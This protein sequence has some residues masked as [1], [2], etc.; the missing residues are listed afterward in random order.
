[1]YLSQ[2]D[3][4]GFKSFAHKTSIKF[5]DGITAIVGPNGCGKTNIV[6]AIRWV[7]GEQKSSVLRS[8]RMD[9][10][11][12]GGTT[13]RR[14]LGFAEVSLVIENTKNILP[15]DYSQVM[16]SRRL[17]RSGDSEYLLNK[18]VCRLKDISNLLMDSGM[19]ADAY[20]VIEL[21]MIEMLLKD[22]DDFRK[23]LFEEAA[24]ITKYKSRRQETLRKLDATRQ[25]LIRVKDII[26]EVERNVN[27]LKSQVNRANRYEK[28]KNELMTVEKLF[29]F[30]KL[31]DLHKRKKPIEMEVAALKNSYANLS[32]KVAKDKAAFEKAQ[33]EIIEKQELLAQAQ[34]KLNKF[35]EHV[36]ATD[37]SIATLRERSAALGETQKRLEIEIASLKEDAEETTA[38]I[39]DSRKQHVSIEHEL[40]SARKKLNE[41]RDKRNIFLEEYKRKKSILLDKNQKAF[42]VLKNLEEKK[43]T[44]DTLMH[45]SKEREKRLES[46]HES[47]NKS[48]GKLK[49]LQKTEL[50]IS[51]QKG[52]L[53]NKIVEEKKNIEELRKSRD[54]LIEEIRNHEL[55]IN[56]L[57]VSLETN[58]TKYQFLDN[59]VEEYGGLPNGVSKILQAKDK[60]AGILG[61]IADLITVPDQYRNAVE[62]ILGEQAHYIVVDSVKNVEKALSYLRSLNSG[63]A[64]FVALDK[65]NADIDVPIHRNENRKD[66]S[67][68]LLVD[69]IKSDKSLIPL[70]NVL[71][72]DVVYVEGDM[73]D[74][75]IR[76]T[77]PCRLVN[78]SGEIVSTDYLYSGGRSKDSDTNI[79]G[80]KD[81]MAEIDGI[82]QDS[83][84]ELEKKVSALQLIKEENGKIISKLSE[85]EYM[86]EN[87]SKELESLH[88]R[89]DIVMYEKNKLEEELEKMISETKQLELFKTDTTQMS[90]IDAEISR[91]ESKR[92]SLEDERDKVQNEEAALETD[93]ENVE[94]NF[95]EYNAQNARI[96]E[97]L[98]GRTKE[99]ERLDLL[100]SNTHADKNKRE[101]SLQEA[102]KLIVTT[103]HK[104]DELKEKLENLF[105]DQRQCEEDVLANREELNTFQEETRS[106]FDSF[107]TIQNEIES[108]KDTIQG[109]KENM[110]EI[111]NEISFLNERM[112]EK[113][114]EIDS[115]EAGIEKYDLDEIIHK[116]QNLLQRVELFGPV[117]LEALDEYDKEKERIQFLISQSEDLAE[118][119]KTLIETIEKINNTAK[120][121]FE[122]TFQLVRTNFKS[123]FTSF[124]GDGEADMQIVETD[125][126]LNSKI[127]VFA[128]PSGKKIQ[129]IA[130]LS[131]GEKSL[132]A[133]AI[134]LAIYKVKPSPFCILD[135]V[136]APLDDA[137]VAR[138]TTMLKDF[139]K[140]TQFIIVTH[141]KK[142]MEAAN[143]LYGVTME[144]TGISKLISV[145]INHEEV[146]T[147]EYNEQT[148]IANPI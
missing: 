21:S 74:T 116:K 58:K 147:D 88:R 22:S 18:Q 80:R 69:E 92:E 77:Y 10:V 89:F 109:K 53:E 135:E 28:L 15:I 110:L 12:F 84:S 5:D 25:D 61:T 86:F 104:I 76:R 134:L 118:A 62:A 68:I 90:K 49:L 8:E 97:S 6:D 101:E 79:I 46:L 20:S 52:K 39:K 19:G 114:I 45:E 131:G 38:R 24:G 72:G 128:Q 14:R 11:I 146:E 99:S 33:N 113:G 55:Q 73:F 129:S 137:N 141:N 124:F 67:D 59:L 66:D 56:E 130:L 148:E 144:E 133:L 42:D 82:I 120:E 40:E 27:A 145:R 3:L 96:K 50:E 143:N 13:N 142:S 115:L 65:I 9:S 1:M 29:Y 30:Y 93:R 117:N 36:R 7:L 91:L 60:V 119:E 95:S 103:N 16:I 107:M 123:I 23:R 31:D 51:N 64:T 81:R 47:H 41:F 126:P 140:D 111:H 139:S 35:S 125:D 71:L 100:L 85:N 48:T 32:G 132:T 63:R 26:N 102:Q 98:L 83:L 78:N 136:D 43:R 57:K 122:Q 112:E 106:E 94:N 138:F 2:V 108:V 4:V 34:D 127:D 54:K 70:L 87:K 37:S 105:N 121:R 44:K 75:K 17:Y